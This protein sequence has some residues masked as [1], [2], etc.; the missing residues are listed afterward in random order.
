MTSRLPL[1]CIHIRGCF[2]SVSQIRQLS[3][4]LAQANAECE[5]ARIGQEA[6]EAALAEA[7]DHIAALQASV[8]SQQAL[9]S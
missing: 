5:Q 1:L 7:K 9:V 2:P 8:D 6:A 3:G 4:A